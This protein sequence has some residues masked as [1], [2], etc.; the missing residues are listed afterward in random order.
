MYRNT[1]EEE[2]WGYLATQDEKQDV[3][4]YPYDE[5]YF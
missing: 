1:H 4:W 5:G 2:A 3:E